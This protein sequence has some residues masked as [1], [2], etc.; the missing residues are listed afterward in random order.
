MTPGA[1]DAEPT[2]DGIDTP[3]G[4]SPPPG[5]AALSGA[6]IVLG[7][8]GGIAAYKAVEILR[9]LEDAGAHVVPVLTEAATR[10]V[11]V[12]TF[13]ALASEP[14]QTALFEADDPI[15]HTRLGRLADLIVVAPATARLL[16]E[17]AAG[18]SADLLGAT[19]LATRAPVVLCPA[20]HAEMWE[21]PAVRANVATLVARGV[22]VVP[23]ETGR[24][25]GGDV[26]AGRLADPATVV[27]AAARVLSA[28]DLAPGRAEVGADAPDELA[29]L[30]VLV[31]AGGTREPIDPVR[32][33]ANRSTGRQGHAI[34]E[35]ALARG[36]AVVLV[37]ASELEVSAGITTIRVETAAQLTEAVL[38]RSA[39]A[40][41]VVMAAAVADFRPARPVS[42][43]LAKRDGVPEL[44]LERTTDVLAE[45]CRRRPPGQVIVGFAAETHDVLERA[46]EKLQAKGAD[47]LVVN[48]VSAPGVGFGH[49]TNAVTVLYATGAEVELP[50]APKPTIAGAVLDAAVSVRA[51]ASP[52]AQRSA[53]T[54]PSPDSQSR[55]DAQQISDKG[56]AR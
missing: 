30:T 11:G 29:G 2:V 44:V 12:A 54:Q 7:V 6:R 52:G 35:V 17:Y 28:R 32:Y 15:P 8:S 10:F 14:A 47:I 13:S 36:A 41:V 50:L 40:D 56:A 18:I 45:L 1:R 34:A 16:G 4:V 33:L 38:S 5:L 39:T 37:T 42:S 27:A 23:P 48:D 22:T 3:P 31:T 20:M 53:T 21:H 46:R 26:G 43:K 51:A 9:R 24:L 25:A 55:T 49:E 19:L